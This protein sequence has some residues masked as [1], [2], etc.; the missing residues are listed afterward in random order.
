ML[1]LSSFEHADQ[2]ISLDRAH[3]AFTQSTGNYPLRAQDRINEAKFR[4]GHYNMG[5]LWQ[6]KKIVDEP[7]QI[8]F[9]L[10]YQRRTDLGKDLPDQPERITVSVTPRRAKRFAFHEGESLHWSL[11]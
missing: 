8:V 3:P 2:D 5:L 10:R 11:G 9:P 1:H 7:S 4:R 6:H